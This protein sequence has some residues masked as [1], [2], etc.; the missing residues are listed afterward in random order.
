M[1][2]PCSRTSPGTNFGPALR[3]G[4]WSFVS[5]IP[6]FCIVWLLGG[7]VGAQAQS[8]SVAE[9]NFT[10]AS[11]PLDASLTNTAVQ[12]SPVSLVANG[13]ITLTRSATGT[14][15]EAAGNTWSGTEDAGFIGARTSL[16]P[17]AAK[18][19]STSFTLT[20]LANGD[21]SNFSISFRY[22]RPTTAPTRARAVIT[23]QQ[24][25]VFKRA[26]TSA[27]TLSG[28]AW[29]TSTTKIAAGDVLPT[30]LS[31]LPCLVELYFWGTSTTPNGIYLDDIKLVCNSLTNVY[32][33]YPASLNSWPQNRAYSA[34]FSVP[35]YTGTP[36][37]SISGSV[38][39]GLTLDT[40]TGELSGIPSA[41]GSST[42][43]ITA[44]GSGGLSASKSYALNIVAPPT[45][46]PVCNSV[47]KLTFDGDT[48]ANSF[49][50]VPPADVASCY[51]EFSF[52]YDASGSM[53]GSIHAGGKNAGSG[54][55]VNAAQGGQMRCF[56]GWDASYAYSTA[57]NE[58][59]HYNIATSSS[60]IRFGVYPGA[61]TA[62]IP[63]AS[64][65]N[66]GEGAVWQT[67]I[68]LDPNASGDLRAFYFDALRWQKDLMDVPGTNGP[69]WA[70]L[71]AYWTN[72]AGVVQRWDS[73]TIDIQAV[74][75]PEHR[76]VNQ[77]NRYWVDL[78]S[79]ATGLNQLIRNTTSKYRSRTV[80]FDLYLWHDAGADLTS[81]T[82]AN[83]PVILIDEIGVAGN[84]TCAAPQ[85]GIGNTVFNDTNY[86][87][88]FDRGEGVAGV[89][90]ELL[91][92]SNSVLTATTTTAGGNYLFS[93]LAEGSYKV[94]IPASEFASGKPLYQ[95]LSISGA[96][97]DN[98]VDD[99]VDENGIDD[100]AP[101]TNGIYS[102]IIV[103]SMDSE[104]S[105]S[106]SGNNSSADE[107][108]DDNTDLTVDFGFVSSPL[109]C[110]GNRVFKDSNGNLIYD[111]GE[112]V[113]GVAVQ[114]LNSSNSV[115]AT[116]TTTNGGLYLFSGLSSNQSYYVRV[117]PSNFAAASVLDGFL[118]VTGNGTDN[119]VDH[120]DNGVDDTAATI[121]GIKSSLITPDASQGGVFG[122][123]WPPSAG[124]SMSNQGGTWYQVTAR[125]N[126][127]TD[128]MDVSVT[129]DTATQNTQA[130]WMVVTNGVTPTSADTNYAAFYLA[131]GTVTVTPYSANPTTSHSLGTVITTVPY[132]VTDIG[133]KRTFRFSLSVSSVNQWSGAPST[134]LGTGFPYDAQGGFPDLFNKKIGLWMRSFADGSATLSGSTW[135]VSWG[136]AADPNIGIFDD[137][138]PLTE[139]GC[140]TTVD[141]GFKPPGPSDFGDWNGSGAAT[142]STS[143]I[144]DSNLRLGASVDAETSVVPDVLATADGADEDG[145]S[146]PLAITQSAMVTVP[147]SVFNNT[148]A[149]AYLHGWID[150]NND[151]TFDDALVSSGGERLEPAR[152]IASNGI[153]Q[154]QSVSFTVPSGAS[155]GTQR[156]VR[157]R[158]TNLAA[159][160]PIGTSGSGEIEDYVVRICSV[161]AVCPAV[162]YLPTATEGAAYSMPITA[163]GGT[164][165]YSYAIV[166]GS[167]NAGLTLNSSSGVIGGSATA[168]GARTFTI[169]ATDS[170]GC[171][172]SRTYTLDVVAA[173]SIIQV[174]GGNGSGN[175]PIERAVY[176]VGAAIN[177]QT[178][179]A[180]GVLVQ[181][182]SAIN[183]TSLT[184]NDAGTS[185]ILTEA[186]LNGASIA[187]L[188]LSSAEANV[189]VLLN[190][191]PTSIASGGVAAFATNAAQVAT[192]T[193]LN[194]YI[195]DDRG[196]G[197]PDATG[198]YDI[199]FNY[200]L[201]TD[202][203]VVVQ[204]R[205]GNSHVQL[206]P[207]DAT[208]NVI[209]GSRTVQVR[210]THDWNT[211]YASATYQ[212]AQPYYLTTIRQSIFG[213]TSPIFGF[214][215]SIFGAD[216]KFF[217]MSENTFTDNP[218]SAGLIG[219]LVW[220]DSNRN[221][222][223]DAGESGASG[224]T[225]RLL[226][227]ATS[228]AV[229]S[230]TTN[231]SGIYSFTSVAPGNYR[232]QFALP[233]GYFFAAQNQGSND[234]RDSDADPATGLTEIF[235]MMPC[236]SLS[237]HDAG[238]YGN[239]YGDHPG[240][241]S[242][243]QTAVAAI[244]IGTN[245]TDVE[246]ANPTVAGANADDTNGTDDEDLSMP[247]F[248]E[249]ATTTL[250]IPVTLN[251]ASLSGNT[252]RIV[253]FV[254]W[255]DDGDVAD[256]NETLA[257]LTV[258][259]NGTSTINF[260]LTP[261]TGIIPGTKYLRIRI[262]EG[263]VVPAFSGASTLK[264]E[265]EDY[266]VTV[267]AA[268]QCF[269]VAGGTTALYRVNHLTGAV[270]TITNA[271][272][273]VKSVAYEGATKTLYYNEYAWP[274]GRLGKYNLVTN[275]HT[276][277]GNL[278]SPT[279][280]TWSYTP[281][282][283]PSSLTYINGKLYYV[284]P[285]TDDLVRIDMNVGETAITNQVKVADL[286]NNARSF[287][288]VGDITA[289][290]D[291]LLW[292]AAHN[293]LGY[294]SPATRLFTTIA[295]YPAYTDPSSAYFMALM[296]DSTTGFLYGQKS[297]AV[298]TAIFRIN[299]TTGA[300]A[301]QASTTP[302][303]DSWD[304]AC[305]E[306]PI[307]LTPP[308]NDFGDWDGSGAGNPFWVADP[309]LSLG[310]RVDAELN[311]SRNASATGDDTTG[312]DD[313]DGVTWPVFQAGGSFKVSV[314]TR[315][316]TPDYC[317]M[318]GWVDWNN[319]GAF[320][321]SEALWTEWGSFVWI[322]PMPTPWTLTGLPAVRVPVGAVT[323]VPLGAR[324]RIIR[325]LEDPPNP[326]S[327][328]TVFGEVE[329][330]TVTV[331]PRG[332]DHGD[333]SSFGDASS[334]TNP[335]FTIGQLV[336]AEATASTTTNGDGDDASN[337]DDE[338]GVWAGVIA[339]GQTNAQIL[340]ELNNTSGVT[341]YL[342]VWVDF[343]RNGSLLD[344][345]EQVAT[346]IVVPNG[347]T[348]HSEAVN[349][350]V[351]AGASVGTAG[352]R[353]RFTTAASPGPVGASAA[354]VSGEVED[355]AIN[356]E[357]AAQSAG[358]YHFAFKDLN[359]DL[360]FLDLGE[361]IP[362]QGN[363]KDYWSGFDTITH[364]WQLD[365]GESVKGWIDNL[366]MK[367]DRAAQ[368]L[369]VDVTIGKNRG[370]DLSQLY[371]AVNSGAMPTQSN[372]LALVYIDGYNAANP[373]VTVYKYDPSL[374]SGTFLNRQLMVSTAAG[375]PNA[376]DVVSKVVTRSASGTRFQLVLNC[377]RINNA[378]NW[379]SYGIIASTWS[380]VQF[381]NTAG[382][383]IHANALIGPQTYD[384]SGNMTVANQGDWRDEEVF[385]DTNPS[386]AFLAEGCFDFGDYAGFGPAFTA[387][388]SSLYLGGAPPDANPIDPSTLATLGDNAIGDDNT[389]SDDEDITPPVLTPGT[390]TNL[391]VPVFN[392]T[393][394]NAFLSV[395]ID[396][397]ANHAVDAGEQVVVNQAVASLAAA[398][399]LSY[400][401]TVPASPALGANLA[402]RYRLSSVSGTGLSG[403]GGFG[404]VEDHMITIDHPVGGLTFD[405]TSLA[406]FPG[407]A[408]QTF[409]SG[410]V[411]ATVTT[412]ENFTPAAWQNYS[413]GPSTTL[414]MRG[415]TGA[416]PPSGNT[417][418]IQVNFSQPLLFQSGIVNLDLDNQSYT[419]E[420]IGGG[421]WSAFKVLDANDREADYNAP[422][423]VG[424]S[425]VT[426]DWNDGTGNSRG[427]DAWWTISGPVTGIK[428]TQRVPGSLTYSGENVSFCFGS[429]TIAP[430]TDYG[431]APAFALASQYTSADI[432]IGS[433]PTDSDL[434]N[435]T[436]G[437]ANVDD[438]T[439]TDDED[440]VM[441]AFTVG[442]ATNLTVPVTLNTAA[443]SGNAA[444]VRVFADWN[445]DGD[446]LDA[447]ETVNGQTVSTNGSSSVTFSITPPTGTPPGAK[448]LRIRATE[449]TA[450]PTFSGSSTLKGEVEDYL[451]NVSSGVVS[452]FGDWNGSGAAT[453]ITSSAFNTN[454]RIGAT[455]D[456]E[457]SVTPDAAASAD[458]ADEDGVWFAPSVTVGSVAQLSVKATNLTASDAYLNA[459]IDFN[460]NGTFDTGEQIAANVVVPAGTTDYDPAGYNSGSAYY[461]YY[462][463]QYNVPT[464][465][466]VG[467]ARG[468]R[469]RLSSVLNTPAVGTSGTG[470][471][472]DYTITFT[473]PA[474]CY[475]FRLA[476]ANGDRVF[477]PAT[478]IVPA[479]INAPI[480]WDQSGDMGSIKSLDA[481]YSPGSKLF[482]FDCT[483]QQIS[484][485]GV[486]A[487]GIWFMLNSGPLPLP[488][489]QRYAI[490]YID[491]F[492]RS[493]PKVTVYVEN[494]T[495]HGSSWLT[496]GNLMVSSAP[497]G[498][499][500]GDVKSLMVT[501]DTTSKTV[502]FR[503]TLDTTRINDRTQWASGY[504]LDADWRGL[505]M[506]STAGMWCTATDMTAAPTYNAVD[507]RATA[508]NMAANSY[509]GIDVHPMGFQP[510]ITESCNYDFGD[511]AF[512][513]TSSAGQTASS[514]IWIGTAVTDAEGDYTDGGAS[515]D[516]GIGV[517]DEDLTMPNF[518]VGIAT[519]LTVPVNIPVLS[520][521]SGSTSRVNIF[522]DWNG[523]GDVADT[524]ETLSPQTVASAGTT[525]LTFSLTAPVGTTVGTKYLRIRITEG[526]TAPAFAG[527][528]NLKGE[529]ED[530][531]VTVSPSM[532][533]GIGNLVWADANDNG[534]FDAGE[535]VSGVRVEL[536]DTSNVLQTFTTT[537][538]A[539]LYQLPV[540]APGTFYVKIP[541][542]QFG[543][544]K[545]LN[546]MSS[547]I[548][549]GPDNGK[550]DDWDENG[551]D[552]GAPASNGIRSPNIVITA[553]GEPTSSETGADGGWDTGIAGRPSDSSADLTIDFG[554]S[555]A[556]TNLYLNGNMEGGT[557]GTSAFPSGGAGIASN[558]AGGDP[559]GSILPSFDWAD[560]GAYIND[561]TH[562]AEGSR[563][564]ALTGNGGCITQDFGVGTV[565][566]GRSSLT[567]G[568]AY[569]FSFDWA[570]FDPAKPAG[571]TAARSEM[572]LEILYSDTSGSSSTQVLRIRSWYDPR[573]N[574]T[575]VNS[576]PLGAWN[577]L[578]WRRCRAQIV[579]PP[580]PPG[581]P[582]I[583]FQLSSG[584]DGHVLLDNFVL[585]PACSN[586]MCSVGNIVFNDS[587]GNGIKDAAESGI[588][589]VWLQIFRQPSSGTPFEVQDLVTHDG[590][591]YF[592]T[593][594]EP[595]DYK[596]VVSADN[597]VSTLPWW[598]GSSALV[599]RVSSSGAGNPNVSATSAVDDQDK[600]LDDAAPQTNGIATATFTLAVGTE[601]VT[602][603]GAE[604]GFMPNIDSGAD[605]SGDL[606][607]DLGF[608][609]SPTTDFG[610][611]I[612]GSLAASMASQ[613]A[614]ADIRI[615]T[616]VTDGEASDPSDANA[617]RDD[618]TG[619]NDE[620]LLIPS[621]TVGE[622]TNLVIP[623]TIPV[624]ANLSGST[625]RIN[626]FADWNGDGDVLDTNE[627][628][629]AQTVAAAGTS[630]VT[631]ALT[632]PAGTT[633]G[634]KYLRIRITE[635]DTVPAFAG[636]SALKGEV[637]DYAFNVSD[638]TETLPAGTY[639]IPMDN[640]L[641][642]NFNLKA[643]GLAVRL[644]HADVALKW[645]INPGKG[646]DGVD[647]TANASRILP[648]AA[649]SQS[650]S[651]RAG[652]LAIYPGS[653][654]QA[655][656]VMAA[657]GNNVAVYQLN[658]A[659]TVNVN[660]NLRH[661]PK[662]AVFDQGG[663]GSQL[664]VP[665]LQEAGL[666]MFTHYQLLNNAADIGAGSCYTIATEPHSDAVSVGAATALV[667]FLLSG[668]NFFGQC[669]A[670]RSYTQHGVL[671]GF[672]SDGTLNGSMMFD[673][674]QDPMAQFEGGLSDESGS[675]TAFTLTSNPGIRIAYSSSDGARYKA[676]AGRIAG[677]PAKGGWV[678]YLAGHSYDIV[679]DIG[680]I[681][682]RRML[683]NAVL[684]SADRPDSCGLSI[685]NG[686]DFGDFSGFVSAGQIASADIRIGTAA[687]DVNV[688]SPA[689]ATATGDDATGTDDEDLTMP[690]FT[691]GNVTNLVIPVVIP[692]PAA[693][694]G[695]TARINVFADWNGDGDV[696]DTNE[697]L[698]AQTVA[699]T[700]NVT[701][702][703]SPPAGTTAGTKYLRIRITEGGV[704]P[705]FSG[706][707]A[708]KGEVEDYAVS[709]VPGLD[710]G[711]Y[712]PFALAQATVVPGLRIGAKVDAEFFATT[713]SFASGDDT[714][715]TDDEDGV[716][717]PPVI[718][719]GAATTMTVTV[720]NTT[721][722]PAYLNVWI[723]FNHNGVVTDAGERLA[724]NTLVN[725]G[726]TNSNL[727]INFTPPASAIEG[728][729]GMR[730][731]LIN[732]TTAVS[733][734]SLGS[735]EIEDYA[736]R[737]C[738]SVGYAY[739][740]GMGNLYEIDVGTGIVRVATAV[741]TG[742][743]KANGAAY[744]ETLGTS[745]VVIF[746]TGFTNDSR[747]AVWDRA[748]GVINVAGDLVNFGFPNSATIHSGDFYNGFYYLVND[749]TD[750]LW[751]VSI[752]GTSGAYAITSATKV[753]DLFN[754][755]R[756]HGYGDFV[757]TPGGVLYAHAW[758]TPGNTPDFYTADLKLA[759]PVATS[760]GTPAFGHNG[761]TLG[762]NGKLYGG[763]GVNADN[764]DWFE[765]S[766][767]TGQSTYI[768]AGFINGLS[769][770]TM[771][772][773]IPAPIITPPANED[774]GD[775]GLFAMAS[776]TVSNNIRMG[777]LVDADSAITLNMGATGDDTTGSDDEDG[778]TLPA[779][780]QAGTSG[781]VSVR[782]TNTSGAP[783]YLCGWIDFNGN[784]SLAD[785][786]EK[787]INNVSIATGTNNVSTNYT[788]NVPATAL[789]GN[790]GL[791]FRLTSTSGAA[792]TGL[793]GTGEV[794]DYVLQILCPTITTAPSALPSATVTMAYST[795]LTAS[796]GNAPYTWAITSGALPAGISLNSTTGVISGT[797]PSTP[798]TTAITF[799]AT[800]AQGCKAST[801]GLTFVVVGLKVGNLVWADTNCNGLKDAAESGIGGIVMSLSTRG[802]NGI[803][804]DGDDVTLKTTTT[805][806]DGTY[807]F[808][809]ISPG[810]YYVKF[811]PPLATYP[812]ATPT[813]VNLDNGIDNDSNAVQPGGGGTVVRSPVIAV[814]AG[815][816]PTSDDG[817]NNSDMT[818]DFGLRPGF[819]IGDLVWNDMNDNGIHEASEPGLTGVTVSLMSPGANG[820]IGGGDDTVVTSTSTNG[821]GN[822]S[823][824][825]PV[826]G[827]FFIRVTPPTGYD[828]PSV[829]VT[830]ADNGVN[831]D[832]NGAQPGGATTFVYSPIFNLT[833]C[834]EPGTAGTTNDEFTIDVGLA[835]N[836]LGIGNTVFRDDNNDG[837]SGPGE[838]ID[839]VT[840]QLY[841]STGTP[842]T[843]TPLATTTTSGGGHYQFINLAR[844]QYIVHIPAV[845]FG[846]SGAMKGM[847]S[848]EGAQTGA[849]DDNL[850]EDGVDSAIPE[851]TGISSR[852]V[853][854]F[855]D[856]A[857]VD[858]GTETGMNYTDDNTLPGG[859]N[860]IDF[861]VDLGFYRWV[862]VGNFVFYDVN[863]D[864]IASASEGV[865]GVRVELYSSGQTPGVDTPL[866]WTT[867]ANG[868]KYLFTK[869]PPGIYRLHIPKTM[870]AS[871][872]PLAGKMSIA[873]GLFG[874]DD[875]GEDG[876]NDTSPQDEGVSSAEVFLVA[877]V[878]PT[879]LNGETGVDNTSDDATDAAINLTVDF[880]FQDPTAVG[881]LVYHDANANGHFDSGEGVDGVLVQLYRSGSVA[882]T[883]PP[884]A[885]MTTSSGGHYKFSGLAGGDYFIHLP[886]S[887]FETN[888][889]LAGLISMS[890]SAT[891]NTDDNVGEDGLDTVSPLNTGISTA[892]FTLRAG[893][894][895]VNSGTE[896]GYLAAEDDANIQDAN[897]N[898]TIDL[899]LVE[900]DPNR[901]GLGN[902]VFNDLNGDGVFTDGE[903]VDGVIVQLYN[904]S[905]TLV[906]TTTTGSGG[907]YLFSNLAPG[908]YYVKL[909]AS[910]W[911][912]SGALKGL[913]SIP[914]QG[915]DNGQDDDLDENG[916]DPA[917]PSTTGVRSTN[918]TLAVNTE[919]TNYDTEVGKNTLIDEGLDENYDLTV[920][921]GFYDRCGVGNLVFVDA[922]GN[923]KADN[924]EGVSGVTVKLFAAGADPRFDTPLATQV[925]E[926]TRKGFFMFLDLNPGAY[927]LHIPA[928]MFQTGGP[929]LGKAS[930][931]GVEATSVDDSSGENGI[932]PGDI[933]D[934]G[935]S[936]EVF[937]LRPGT[938]P[939]TTETGLFGNAD[940]S[941]PNGISGYNI[942][943]TKDFGFV[944]NACIGNLVFKDLD[945]DGKFTSGVDVG[946][947]GVTVQLWSGTTLKDTKVTAN[948]GLYEFCT[949]PGSYSIKIPASMFQTGAPLAYLQ[950][951]TLG[952][953][954]AT[955]ST[956]NWQDD[957]GGQDASDNG[958]PLTNGASTGTFA[959]AVNTMPGPQTGET[960]FA[961]SSDDMTETDVNLTIDLG[962]KPLPL[963]AGNLVFNDANSNGLK[964][965]NEAG[966]AGVTVK[967]FADT[968][969]PQTGTATATAITGTDGSFMLQTFA[970]GQYFIHVPKTMFA[971]GAPLAGM[972]SSP[973]AGAGAADDNVDENGLDSA[974]PTTTGVSTGLFSLVYGAAP[975]DSGTEKGVL[976]T[977]D[978]AADANGNLTLDLGFRVP[979]PGTPLAGRVRRDLNGDGMATTADAPLSGVEVAVYVDENQ[980]AILDP[981]EANAVATTQSSADGTYLF[982]GLAPDAYLVQA[983]PLPGSQAVA[984]SDGGAPDQTSVVLGT[985]PV[986][987]IDFLQCPCPDTFAQW[988]A[989]HDLGT[990]AGASDDPDGDGLDNLAEYALGSDPKQGV[991]SS[992]AFRLEATAG[993]DA[994]LRR[995]VQG[996][997]DLRYVIE[998]SR[999]AS[1000]WTKLSVVSTSTV[1001]GNDELLRYTPVAQDPVFQAQG[1002]GFVRL[1003]IERDAD[1004]DGTAE[1005]VSLSAVQ[1006]FA[1007]R[1008][1009]GA[1010]ETTFSMPLLREALYSGRIIETGEHTLGIAAGAGLKAALGTGR[1011]CFVEIV[1012]GAHVGQCFD[1013]DEATTTDSVLAI[1014]LASA[1015]NTASSL[1016]AGLVDARVTVRAHW[1017]L[1018]DLLPAARFHAT[1019]SASTADRVMFF[1020]SGGYVVNWLLAT[1021]QGSRWVRTAD[1022]TF[1023]DMGRARLVTAIDGCFVQSRGGAVTLP[1024]VGEVRTAPMVRKA[1025]SNMQLLG[1026]SAALA[1027]TFDSL[1028]TARSGDKLRLWNADQVAGSSGFDGFTR[1029]ADGW[1030]RD[1031][1032]QTSVDTSVHLDPFRAFFLAPAAPS[1033]GAAP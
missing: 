877:G 727:T 43:T 84:F 597:F 7:L 280:G 921:F 821:A 93:G 661:K 795:T 991:R 171:S 83:P 970:E 226:D 340:V 417:R 853:S 76:A 288:W 530:Y 926:T 356:I 904:T 463:L 738:P 960:G 444:R 521:I 358:C 700:G 343:N 1009:F 875:V 328:G 725:T 906:A 360:D 971:T 87:G 57:R 879:A 251:T 793:V 690:S 844:D 804:Y 227:A 560:Q 434:G 763:L 315:N 974:T 724:T 629:T 296:H 617:N 239:D 679:G 331:Q 822:Y 543:A 1014:D 387:I 420:L 922:N 11:T 500:A 825:S 178:T 882:G 894:M 579:V 199:R 1033:V 857:P 423:G 975:V 2:S 249:G 699:A 580:A 907:C 656:A 698:T 228:A 77:Y 934:E 1019:T 1008:D 915:G 557:A 153:V 349:F 145:V 20:A 163:V 647:F 940:N 823:F 395:W 218:T 552:D 333:F 375:G 379:A 602:G 841:R 460:N 49:S 364:N 79:G 172:V 485:T 796:G 627:T 688:S 415:G 47:A 797:A 662:I 720:T 295:S 493:A 863:G 768:N 438:T 591:Q 664:H 962:F 447:N 138:M 96:G 878:A 919:P 114:L 291:G 217:A 786:G 659:V 276:N 160:G 537:D 572:M 393:G 1025:V 831:D 948:G 625:S 639:I 566:A 405:F 635:G 124:A 549:N 750:D 765:V 815:S 523:D 788:I 816:E 100:A 169:Q 483:V 346:N 1024:F 284:H 989:Q 784:G 802:P 740:T 520:S 61:N 924:N 719:A 968:V 336:D 761:I 950:A 403:A 286:T 603:A 1002:R 541:A 954:M 135:T 553:A 245:A 711:D 38:P 859:D 615:G 416:T 238:I 1026:T 753:A 373:V 120:D 369:T 732:A 40:S 865:N 314:D 82:T 650:V 8:V 264:G 222:I 466:S 751:K 214:R 482:T 282:Q 901:V 564:F 848:V 723:D 283:R 687:T 994:L 601:P 811:T 993:I 383:W 344:A 211:G 1022:A 42:F 241:P 256:A 917:S 339:Q 561:Y 337:N 301:I 73:P 347:S 587:N 10:N 630:N 289:T 368:Q 744:A 173:G 101:A 365:P 190:G 212:S 710:F 4:A 103:L 959:T 983:L 418:T 174:V 207:L 892:V 714:T 467:A 372:N 812:L 644:L 28:T 634:T 465:A 352:V 759:T 680:S 584:G 21:W 671:A 48:S 846:T 108:D 234:A 429:F 167:L 433:V 442:V 538:A 746:A 570:P 528:S 900:P 678:H 102:G 478:E 302:V 192:N 179:E 514:D 842:G 754:N 176:Q 187:N 850:G 860:D 742:F 412:S 411:T 896:T 965:A 306:P 513:I 623:V 777:A 69:R 70:E 621:F 257:A 382:M 104:P 402:V 769:D 213:T 534:R 898:M 681:N 951:T 243:S 479:Q 458:G 455:V 194:H 201:T 186:N 876:L 1021:P 673:N 778:V 941:S 947:D 224:V 308:V 123:T 819:R 866:A 743:D 803:A 622:V 986:T 370:A 575:A 210:G 313:E 889:P 643:Y 128:Q 663:H 512:G 826:A 880:G 791:R 115:L 734:G 829:I 421:V 595:G 89:R 311:S 80:F 733:S 235:T 409:T 672:E 938:M 237:H 558:W 151:G 278:N 435:P 488:N 334:L 202:D 755:T 475:H 107:A 437:T 929:L 105:T 268:A 705:T 739:G 930:M 378:A 464:T 905:N 498:L 624:V 94:R 809:D 798:S 756:A 610:D 425:I 16:T 916:D 182:N 216:C 323:G 39:T 410:G 292:V 598:G 729:S 642:G 480:Y 935:I 126:Y 230:T 577:A 121:N 707:L 532:T 806:A 767:S 424:S 590:G 75:L 589:N 303:H 391:V 511:H 708:L 413:G 267:N 392:N 408:G 407:M 600:G 143:S 884:V 757:I 972:N 910:N 766:L 588:D 170:T 709:V 782:V 431:D 772:A 436:T 527:V 445:G 942:D 322:D 946:V 573:T 440:V 701:F 99:G 519:A 388:S 362:S 505:Q 25:G 890:G 317:S 13:G 23:W 667:D 44:T 833:Q 74:Y 18:S 60:Q 66:K 987:Y 883:V 619:I 92:T 515:L 132:T 247:V 208:G 1029:T 747:L 668:G 477:N 563:F 157:F 507:G 845:M 596:V 152:S 547:L 30:T 22:Q 897:G 651:F 510:V 193:N 648:T 847:L 468:V 908:T 862:G 964:D 909:P 731:S 1011:E 685:M 248:T 119:G 704:A 697:T 574:S 981:A 628:L 562:A 371:F 277:I 85:M 161:M 655:L 380:G 660:A 506:T 669:A 471:I 422:V 920:D 958:S 792:P 219:D 72:D 912:G 448:Y 654:A 984:D 606:T 129:L 5:L 446:V 722:A 204:E 715:G 33:L 943:L 35:G 881:N 110:V 1027:Q 134:W 813:V 154:V 357:P 717:W 52:G 27:I 244:R 914:G 607:I 814:A 864:G 271:P 682:G 355:V 1006:G 231:A 649:A 106:E 891:V 188:S 232:V 316:S 240:F 272:Y 29:T 985:K 780:I 399:S 255:N 137:V 952:S 374:S 189:G 338:D 318:Q 426:L 641:Q 298:S 427:D 1015:R 928:A 389:G 949:V 568:Q 657:Y 501:E 758:I 675:V 348:Y 31:N 495:S 496:P 593:G 799:Q 476:D 63:T 158:L 868:G 609:G 386:S 451:I 997:Q 652:P 801:S 805:A 484:A 225:V 684:R 874:D 775:Y 540:S 236:D 53:S 594:L 832:N 887:N 995:P 9:W 693:L 450:G 252:S 147:V 918:I 456:S 1032:D 71:H 583:S 342:N 789:V 885:Q 474:P 125:H 140:D 614:S 377:A 937:I 183:L 852:I 961:S 50:P 637:E 131:N 351:P 1012:S 612:F 165:G 586:K 686:A 886:I 851:T 666:T 764:A 51:G 996:H 638:G 32:A 1031:V 741:P 449:G 81:L 676:Y 955:G 571:D 221:G 658:T 300:E 113:D 184:V 136:G 299:K 718:A 936:T 939:S 88:H 1003:R 834:K 285:G 65:T 166:S 988:Q 499:N 206:Q 36:T 156:G 536:Y 973:G 327:Y 470:E 14:I 430:G 1:A 26:Y 345:G 64:Q 1001:D 867:T 95:L 350:D 118:S 923:G 927:F 497:N 548:G 794:E 556:A 159:T 133:P 1028:T 307:D 748:T 931:T 524:G 397:N 146:M 502:R 58:L 191:T 330:Y 616:N 401:I 324:V 55:P 856:A 702:S 781:T 873:P 504:S 828:V 253:V 139:V 872:G 443:L 665:V 824:T 869:M 838:G 969:D 175:V 633:G 810:S 992:S 54:N 312:V 144:R 827:N 309:A 473:A 1023:A 518:P 78:N 1010:T 320:E 779:S 899:G 835:P 404:E 454:L 209:A 976:A 933:A 956:T 569:N 820:L 870:F 895:P 381:A 223:Q 967:L 545:P 353:V 242:A 195:Y 585:T 263:T 893:S 354:G 783:A 90:V 749:D 162:S 321:A 776:G 281:S 185:K 771:G 677:A 394:S 576:R 390:A 270:T 98:G 59:L 745:G 6:A 817:D 229:A 640:A 385:I 840:V 297:A 262:V 361:T 116:Q 1020:E 396:Y 287:G 111:P 581:K 155:V 800:D 774:N 319:N 215:L 613:T 551:I 692:V 117:A 459:W 531:V 198:E 925:T 472:E 546:G 1013:L 439:G 843:S 97:G 168:I 279:S 491:G 148:G 525:N 674:F 550:D 164:P 888:G 762:L 487:D 329:D 517:D 998:G 363:V 691:V 325:S 592:F 999:D 367:Y 808:T 305:A 37:W 149:N 341:G 645:I 130:L 45:P 3:K 653:E 260:S 290:P 636:A 953:F 481:T 604:N 611:H 911:T 837:H 273:N 19:L 1005:D 830:S 977:A 565:V 1004:L 259:T 542:T 177:T 233:A 246:A 332:S 310:A 726:V 559:S 626:V 203:Y 122:Y 141:F 34:K 68:K 858:S 683:L 807:Q 902:A 46:M 503:L 384:S 861:T 414:Y 555:C 632:P 982:E 254:D 494:S 855:N 526:S 205:N 721:G 631:F 945:R 335:T 432:R 790:V 695:S 400:P 773:C 62:S 12:T 716:T 197:E 713:D 836:T 1017:T 180:G 441:P 181:T 366:D 533:Y 736:M 582:V 696:A 265:V 492:N 605:A 452:D 854:L 261:P 818:V 535:G 522:V 469:V 91:N 980:N 17:R 398:Q 509:I 770:M 200:A 620:D 428:I 990:Q 67:R 752:T 127:V 109:F 735:G 728:I 932:D 326:V 730:V 694:S 486:R 712:T 489:V 1018:R 196:E 760:L 112:G 737:V 274:N 849:Q 966:V 376:S 608:Q 86:N 258:S 266:A 539:G 56:L 578:D 294:W 1030:V 457:V 250:T 150:L 1000:I 944:S 567:A 785:A 670:V 903:G 269:S 703:L 871:T 293:E 359:R 1016:P 15:F 839:G 419:F 706:S 516:D 554:F 41:I 275:T 544:G 142:A 963:T 978:N 646:K 24:A 220:N 453:A 406:S 618:I 462:R 461:Q 490:V 1007:L 689:N 913:L 787:F 979:P 599:G 957:N 304:Y 508:M 529:V